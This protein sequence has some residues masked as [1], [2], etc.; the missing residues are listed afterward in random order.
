MKAPDEDR[1]DRAI[2]R[3]AE[4]LGGLP[5]DVA[6]DI[7]DAVA[8]RVREELP[9]WARAAGTGTMTRLSLS[10]TGRPLQSAWKPWRT[11]NRGKQSAGRWSTCR[12]P[13]RNRRRVG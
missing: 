4:D 1:R 9:R 2:R 8:E 10:P 11:L 12:R 3:L 13:Q 7:L 6:A 5:A